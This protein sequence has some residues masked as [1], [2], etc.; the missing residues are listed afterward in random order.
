MLSPILPLNKKIFKIVL[1]VILLGC[2]GCTQSKQHQIKFSPEEKQWLLNHDKIVLAVDNSYPPL[3]YI[4]DDGQ[5][6]GLNIDL[7]KLVGQQ[8]NISIELEGSD[9][10]EALEKALNH[11][12]DGVINATPLEERKSKLNFSEE[13]FRDPLALV[14]YKDTEIDDFDNIKFQRIAA[15]RGSRH[16]LVLQEK[17]PPYLIVPIANLEEGIGLLSQRKV[18]GIYDDLAPLYHIISSSGYSHLKVAFVETNSLGA[19]IGLRNNDPLLLSVLNKAISSITNEDR[20]SIQDKWLGFSPARDYT[21]YYITIGILMAV[22]MLIS[23]WTWSLKTMVKSKTRELNSE[24]QRRKQT[25]AELIRSKERAEESDR[26]KSAFLAN[27]SHEIR[28]PMNG[29]FGFSE[30]LQLNTF[31]EDE[32]NKYLGLIF[33]SAQQLLSIINDLVNISKLEANLVEVNK[34]EVNLHEMVSDLFALHKLKAEKLA[35]DF[36]YSYELE[37][38][39]RF[40]VDKVK[41]RQVLTN[42]ISNAIKNTKDG[43][44]HFGVEPYGDGEFLRFFVCDTGIGIDVENHEHIFNRFW[45]LKSGSDQGGTGLGLAISKAHVEL[46]G[47]KI[48]VESEL[49]KGAH[50]SFTVPL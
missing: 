35:L 6:T 12:V 11:E 3:N 33:S 13:F 39:E 32:Q 44:V 48:W 24:L 34:E 41:V 5:L 42:L 37:E 20:L 22:V 14:T 47:G 17:I 16:L 40:N 25:E 28:T 7:V 10:D 23:L 18:D 43:S 36:S 46:M 2:Y 15:K 27:I 8:L 9:W 50:F 31:S 1:F 4:G 30:L 21:V 19:S 49:K 26:L 29:I 38:S 45:K